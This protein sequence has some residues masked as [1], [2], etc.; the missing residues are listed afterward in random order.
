MGKTIKEMMMDVLLSSK[1]SSHLGCFQ[2]NPSILTGFTLNHH[3]EK[4]P[5]MELAV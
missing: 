3:T 5:L 4:D 1:A 2:S